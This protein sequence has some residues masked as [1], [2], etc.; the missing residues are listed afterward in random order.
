M[1]DWTLYG[2]YIWFKVLMHIA[3]VHEEKLLD[4]SEHVSRAHLY[5]HSG[6]RKLIGEWWNVSY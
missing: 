3:E 4:S 5:I 6:G 1:I 2:I